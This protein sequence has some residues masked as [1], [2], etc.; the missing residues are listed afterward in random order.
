MVVAG[1]GN[2]GDAENLPQFPA[3]LKDDADRPGRDDAAGL[4]TIAVTCTGPEPVPV[5]C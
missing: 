4:A 2:D 3:T 5:R 1:A